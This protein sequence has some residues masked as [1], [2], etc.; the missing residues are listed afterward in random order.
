MEELKKKTFKCVEKRIDLFEKIILENNKKLEK[1][2]I[3]LGS[4]VSLNSSS[5]EKEFLF[6]SILLSKNGRRCDQMQAVI[7]EDQKK[8]EMLRI[9]R[10]YTEADAQE[11]AKVDEQLTALL[12]KAN[13]TTQG[14]PSTINATPEDVLSISTQ[15]ETTSLSI[16]KNIQEIGEMIRKGHGSLSE[17]K[18][19]YS[20]LE[21]EL[22]IESLAKISFKPEQEIIKGS[23]QN[24][25]KKIKEITL[26]KA[27][28]G[29]E[30]SKQTKAFEEMSSKI[31][32]KAPTLVE[33]AMDVP[34]PQSFIGQISL[35]SKEALT[36]PQK[37]T[38]TLKLEANQIVR[39]MLA[40]TIEPKEEQARAPFQE[41]NPALNISPSPPFSR[42]S[43]ET[44]DPFSQAPRQSSTAQESQKSTNCF[45][46]LHQSPFTQ[47]HAPSSFSQPFQQ[48]KFGAS[49]FE[50][51]LKAIPP[52]RTEHSDEKKQQGGAFMQ[53]ANI[54]FGAFSRKK[55]ETQ[56]GNADRKN[57]LPSSFSGFR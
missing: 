6:A 4:A 25:D 31:K 50:T 16:S 29:P 17:K 41:H 57:D 40:P 49:S 48:Y 30:I 2:K 55:D 8:L 32:E 35:G 34:L 5:L 7:R 10:F 9:N 20:L 12:L 54:S 22:I 47:A 56:G 43:A 53:K 18:D 52:A 46:E 24:L 28:K 44:T 11:W 33:A 13:A 14:P 21:E 39:P 26:Q 19:A 42:K 38:D 36:S 45:P 1:L 3:E 27:L 23:V 37:T 15:L 51:Q